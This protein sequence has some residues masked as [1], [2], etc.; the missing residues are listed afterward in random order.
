VFK[1]LATSAGAAF[2]GFI[3][4]GI[5]A[6]V[7]TVQDELRLSVNVKQFGAVCDGVT[8]DSAAVQ[9]AINYCATFTRWPAL[10]V[11]GRCFLGSSVN[12]DRM[13]DTTLSEFRII[14]EGEGAGFYTSGNVTMF[15]STI[16]I[17]TAPLS[18][19]VTFE[20]IHFETSSIFNTSYV[21][22]PKFLRVKF[23]N[24]NFR[25]IR[26]INSTIYVQTLHFSKCN[27]RNNAANFINC[28]GL[29]DVSFSSQCIIENAN[30][31]V[32]SIDAVR[33]TNGL[34]ILDS[35]IEGMQTSTV[36]CTGAAG[37]KISGN[38]IESNVANDYNFFGGGIANK[39]IEITGNYIYAPNGNVF[40]YGP[41]TALYSAGNTVSLSTAGTYL[42]AN[43]IQITDANSTADV[44]L[45]L[46]ALTDAVTIRKMN[47][48]TRFGNTQDV[49]T[50]SA[51]HIT[52][53][54]AGN[55]GIGKPAGA[56]VR[57]GV[58]GAN[59]ASTD[60]AQVLYDSVGNTIAAF[61]N[62]RVIQFGVINAY[63]NDTTAAAG[64]VPIGGLY[65]IGNAIQIRLV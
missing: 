9:L 14:G 12:I 52:K 55:F 37:L 24:C 65:R 30:T 20:N 25:L 36:V 39:S 61:R 6:V 19:F 29:Y 59:Q 47:G 49:W 54:A 44:V 48:E 51:N 5:G 11:P 15:D 53:S 21:L 23:H 43:G 2:I 27:I 32:R 40:Y 41:T 63:T 57:W 46:G 31:L 22:S 50:D 8:D 64:G 35:V 60:F 33:G 4:S 3:Q 1:T 10:R 13:V 38:H 62:D 42:H 17:T 16:P 58:M 45:G 26:C 7:R 56:S 18:E 34:R 28:A